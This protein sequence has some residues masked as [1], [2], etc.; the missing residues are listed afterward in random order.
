MTKASA[1]DTSSTLVELVVNDVLNLVA[2]SLSR[3]ANLDGL[4]LLEFTFIEL[5]H[6][7]ILDVDR[8]ACTSGAHKESW[9]LIDDAEFLDVAV[10]DSVDRR[11]NDLLHNLVLAKVV[12]LVFID[13]VHPVRPLILVAIIDVVID[14]TSI[15]LGG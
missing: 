3:E 12:N 5:V 13:R 14:G 2:A 8:F 7:D 9:N 15:E 11:D 6:E 1:K 4:V 10:S